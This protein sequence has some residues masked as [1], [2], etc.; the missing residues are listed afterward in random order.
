MFFV[1]RSAF[2]LGLV[3]SA[4]DWPGDGRL[5]DDLKEAAKPVATQ[6]MSAATT[7]IEK[8]CVSNLPA[9]ID[10][11]ARLNR[12]ASDAADVA[13]PHPVPGRPRS[14]SVDTLTPGDLAPHWRGAAKPHSASTRS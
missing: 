12:L 9:C 10:G 3:Y 5:T 14:T 7:K 1:V 2:W 6:A 4:I 8:T 11:A 13:K